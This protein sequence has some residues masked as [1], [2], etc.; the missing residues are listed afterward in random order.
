M[1]LSMKIVEVS[2]HTFFGILRASNWTYAS[3]QLRG[4]ERRFA[5]LRG[6]RPV[7]KKAP[8]RSG[9]FKA[10]IGEVRPL[11]STCDWQRPL[12]RFVP[13]AGTICAVFL[14]ILPK[15]GPAGIE[16]GNRRRRP[17]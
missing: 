10:R 8:D 1:A 11:S 13:L 4:T 15:G 16:Q 2:E 6:I 14:S 7:R 9:A 12:F 3:K 17:Q 5:R